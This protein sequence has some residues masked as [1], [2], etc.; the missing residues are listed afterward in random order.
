MVGTVVGGSTVTTGL[1]WGQ[2]YA[3][4]G[5]CSPDSCAHS[6]V[7]VVQIGVGL[8]LSVKCLYPSM[9]RAYRKEVGAG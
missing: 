6:K 7:P 5:P 8:T 4:A 3:Y 2:F 9:S 1:G